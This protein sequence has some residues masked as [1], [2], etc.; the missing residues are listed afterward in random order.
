[1]AN[2]LE[3][4]GLRRFSG[5]FDWM[6]G[7]DFIQRFDLFLNRFR[8][9]FDKSDLRFIGM[10]PGNGRAV[11]MND[12][13]GLSYN[14]DFTNPDLFDA[15]YPAVAEKYARRINRVLEKMNGGGRTLICYAEFRTKAERQGESL[16]ELIAKAN[17]E[18]GAPIDLFY[19]RHNPKMRPGE[20]E[21]RRVNENLFVAEYFAPLAG[22]SE[23]VAEKEELIA[24]ALKN[25]LLKVA[26]QKSL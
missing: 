7:A 4:A 25:T 18:Y 16:E 24:A 2:A 8:H 6:S 5:P 23:A 19:A 3:A 10:D 21:L 17:A 15:E 14:H 9:Y 20:I 12:R 1:M 22:F 11:Y 13:T 26:Q